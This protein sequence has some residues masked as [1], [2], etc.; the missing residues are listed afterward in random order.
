MLFAAKTITLKDG[1]IAILRAPN[2]GDAPQ[3]LAL[4]QTT[5]LQTPYLTTAPEDCRDMTAQ[6]EEQWIIRQ[7]ESPAVLPILCEVDGKLAGNCEVRFSLRTKTGHRANIG[8]AL[9]QEYWGLGIGTAMF[10]AMLD[11]ARDFGATHAELAFIEGNSRA[12]ALYEKMGF[13]LVGVMPEAVRQQDGSLV[14]EYWMQR[15]L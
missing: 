5:I 9:M 6:Q 3:L 2:A 8:I 7:V 15:R 12:R 13:R 1:R 4:L 11:A 14:N 10:E